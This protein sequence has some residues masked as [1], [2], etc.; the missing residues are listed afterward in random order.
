M[1]SIQT[2]TLPVEAE[3]LQFLW[4]EITGRCNLSC[5]HCYADSGPSVNVDNE[6]TYVDYERI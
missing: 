4:L 3:G 2:T 6:L 5:V 1:T